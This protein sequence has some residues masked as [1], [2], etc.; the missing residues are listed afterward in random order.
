[1]PQLGLVPQSGWNG[2]S[3]PIE[4]TYFAELASTGRLSI[5]VFHGLSIGKTCFPCRLALTP[6]SGSLSGAACESATLMPIAARDEK[7]R[8]RFM[9]SLRFGAAFQN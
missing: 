4:A 5:G 1:M 7:A 8:R 3:A 9:E 2:A 6:R